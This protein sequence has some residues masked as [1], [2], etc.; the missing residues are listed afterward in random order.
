MIEIK[1]IRCP[2]VVTRPVTK[3]EKIQYCKTTLFTVQNVSRKY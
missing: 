2:V 1:W 3:L